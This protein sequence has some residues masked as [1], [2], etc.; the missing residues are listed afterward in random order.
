MDKEY[1]KYLDIYLKEKAL[2]MSGKKKYKKCDDCSTDKKFIEKDNKLIYSCGSTGSECGDQLSITLPEYIDY[3]KEKER[4]NNIIHGSFHYNK[5]DILSSY[6]LKDLEK[7]MDIKEFKEKQDQEIKQATEQLDN[8][9][10]LYLK[11]N[12]LTKR[13]EEIQLIHKLKRN[14]IIRKKDILYE[15]KQRTTTDERK[16]ELR[17]EY[18]KIIHENNKIIYPAIEYLN[19]SLKY[20]LPTKNYEIKVSND[21]LE[22]KMK[23]KTKKEK[24]K[25]KEENEEKLIEII[26]DHFKNNNGILKKKEYSKIKGD[27]KTK[28]GSTLFSSLRYLPNQ[29]KKKPWLKTEQ[30]KYGPIIEEPPTNALSIKVTENWRDY[31]KIENKNSA[32]FDNT[33]NKSESK[34]KVKKTPEENMEPIK[35]FSRSKENKWLSAFNKGKEFTYDGYSYP[36]VEHAFHAQKIDPEDPQSE[37][38]KTKLSDKDL[39]ANEAKK[40]G[41]KASFKENKYQFRDD[42]DKIKLKLMKEITEEYYKANPKYL[43]KLKETGKKE[44]LHSGPR[45]DKFWGITKD[46]GENHHGKILMEIRDKMEMP[47]KTKKLTKEGKKWAKEASKVMKQMVE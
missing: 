16:N 6:N 28:W 21:E 25:V 42:W 4:L 47:I 43:K 45:I 20:I 27:Y 35:Y 9:N 44:L 13:N 24:N 36:T 7:N 5:E 32:K 22:D 34:D 8:L 3:N 12:E 31:L 17:K 19:T 29:V 41:G 33:E 23:E 11:E 39:K 30:E 26:I 2:F 10:S 14:S 37:S 15:F 46:G 38:Y 40:L 1:S 18:A